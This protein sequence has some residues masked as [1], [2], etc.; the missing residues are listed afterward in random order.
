MRL[1]KDTLVKQQF[2]IVLSLFVPMVFIGLLLMSNSVTGITKTT[3]KDIDNT[4]KKLAGFKD[5]KSPNW[6][7]K[8]KE[9]EK[10]AKEKREAAWKEAW[11]SQEN[12]FTWPPNVQAAAKGKYF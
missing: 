2:W 9:G 7:S 6:V 11:A 12:L 5:I 8:V 4:K 3:D 1:D 10:V